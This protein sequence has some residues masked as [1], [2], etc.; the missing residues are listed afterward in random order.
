M[1]MNGNMCRLG[2]TGSQLFD[3]V[4]S[5]GQAYGPVGGGR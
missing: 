2:L 5:T 4:P 3:T 1:M